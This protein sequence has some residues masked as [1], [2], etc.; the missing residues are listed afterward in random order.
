MLGVRACRGGAIGRVPPSLTLVGASTARR[1]PA[2]IRSASAR[3]KSPLMTADVVTGLLTTGA[4]TTAPS[5]R[6]ASGLPTWPPVARAIFAAPSPVNV[7][8]MPNVVAVLPGDRLRTGD[9]AVGEDRL[10]VQIQLARAS[11]D[12]GFAQARGR[13]RLRRAAPRSAP[14]RRRSRRSTKS[15]PP[16]SRRPRRPPPRSPAAVRERLERYRLQRLRGS[17]GRPSPTR[18]RLSRRSASL[19]GGSNDSGS[20][21]R[22][23]LGQ[24]LHRISPICDWSSGLQLA[25]GHRE[26]PAHG[27]DVDAEA[28]GNGRAAQALDF[29][30]DD[31]G[32]APWMQHV[33]RGPDRP[34]GDEGR[35]DR[36]GVRRGLGPERGGVACPDRRLAPL[37]P[38]DV[39]QHPDEPGFLAGLA[40]GNRSPGAGGFDERVLN[41][42]VRFVGAT[43]EPPG[44]TVKTLF[45]RVV[46]GRQQAAPGGLLGGVACRVSGLRCL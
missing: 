34:L 19:R 28:R 40:R 14:P 3:V 18:C 9:V 20:A 33:E 10:F 22:S 36:R 39:D 13:S 17:A 31:D 1:S 29:V 25:P 6:I 11:R 35:F 37:I 5:M 43:G 46:Q 21:S 42:V 12:D 44:E 32:A 15:S 41:Q 38:A 30:H 4:I 16:S 27:D 7:M 2:T 8:A 24:G 23:R 45:V 26:M